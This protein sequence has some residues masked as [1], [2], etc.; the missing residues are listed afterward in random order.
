MR[1]RKL[2]FNDVL[3][4]ANVEEL[5][6]EYKYQNLND[7]YAE[8]G[9]GRYTATTILNSILHDARETKKSAILERAKKAE[10]PTTKSKD[11]IIVSGIDN[12]KITLANCCRPIKGDKIIGYITKGYG[13]TVHQATCHN[14]VN[15]D[16]LIEVNWND[17]I[18]KKYPTNLLITTEKDDDVLLKIISKIS[19]YDI[20][21]KSINT[22]VNPDLL[23]YDI[24]VMVNNTENINKCLVDLSS[25]NHVIKAERIIK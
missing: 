17:E 5:L 19:I 14:I 4:D 8:I 11:D 20:S 3:T 9:S 15:A 24:I 6:K 22:L 1:K 10:V 7:C 25:I 21:V 18:T 13:I 12:M 23:I 16:R 2:A